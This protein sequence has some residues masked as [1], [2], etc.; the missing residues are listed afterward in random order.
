VDR[1]EAVLGHAEQRAEPT[2][3]LQPK[4]PAE[5]LAPS[6]NLLRSSH[7]SWRLLG[8][9]SAPPSSSSSAL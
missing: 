6:K 7:F 9:A 2:H 1:G 5:D 4:P 8:Y 3:P